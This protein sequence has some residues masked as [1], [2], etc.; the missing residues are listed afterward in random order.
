MWL[1]PRA[2]AHAQA[3]EPAVVVAAVPARLAVLDLEA[4]LDGGVFL[5]EEEVAA[6]GD[7]RGVGLAVLA[8][9]QPERSLLRHHPQ[10]PGPIAV[11]ARATVPLRVG[12]RGA[13]NGR[14][15]Q[16]EEEP[17]DVLLEIR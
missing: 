9:A 7:E 1:V 8:G 12:R 13:G 15:G 16:T 5:V 2:G 3:H 11:L 4:Q 17:L 14:L 6:L 10:E